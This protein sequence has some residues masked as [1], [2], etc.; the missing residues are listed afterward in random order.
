MM[1]ESCPSIKRKPVSVF[2]NFEMVWTC[3]P[4]DEFSLLFI[5]ISS[6]KFD[7]SVSRSTEENEEGH[8]LIK[9]PG[10]AS[11]VLCNM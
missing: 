7:Q 1:K 10:V 5:A 6:H 3:L 11:G 9:M 4:Q 2:I 8:T